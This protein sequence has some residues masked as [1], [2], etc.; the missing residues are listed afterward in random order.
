MESLWLTA[1]C[2]KKLRTRFSSGAIVAGQIPCH[3][4]IGLVIDYANFLLFSPILVFLFRVLIA[5]FTVASPAGW[6]SLSGYTVG[7][8]EAV[9]VHR[10]GFLPLSIIRMS[11][12]IIKLTKCR[13]FCLVGLLSPVASFAM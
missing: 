6:G 9:I 7:G 4:R 12:L 1:S 10:R 5:I 3:S 13:P 8:P 2:A 11:F